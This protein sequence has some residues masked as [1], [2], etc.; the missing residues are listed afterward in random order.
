VLD[1]GLARMR[2]IEGVA[3]NISNS[4]T[5]MS[6]S[7]PG[8]IMGTAA[9]M[10]PEQARGRDVDKRADI[11]AFGVVLY[12]LLTGERLFKGEDAADTL[13][14]VLTKE[15][16]LDRVPVKVRK[17]LRRCLEKD[18]KRCLRNVRTDRDAGLTDC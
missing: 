14:L 10:A 11:W 16:D 9:Y 2:E 6:A 13:A 18:Q 7:S 1:F 3:T 4:P 8:T 15:P 12:E 5:L 17:L